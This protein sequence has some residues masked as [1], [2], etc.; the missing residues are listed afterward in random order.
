MSVSDPAAAPL[1]EKCGTIGV[2]SYLVLSPVLQ[3]WRCP[4][5]FH[6]WTTLKTRIERHQEAYALDSFPPSARSECPECC[7]TDVITLTDVLSSDRV[8]YFRCRACDCWWMV[9]KG[10]NGPA[11]RAIFGN[12]DTSSFRKDDKTG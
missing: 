8:D 9:P 5:C 3:Y 4:Y 10:R 12:P 11:T 6:I 2:P 1:C 7:A